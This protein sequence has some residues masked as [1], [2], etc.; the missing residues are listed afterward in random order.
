MCDRWGDLLSIKRLTVCLGTTYLTS[1]ISSTGLQGQTLTE[2]EPVVMKPGESHK[3]TCTAAGFTFS[4]YYMAWIRQAPGKGLE[5]IAYISSG[6]VSKFYSQSVQG[7]STISRDNDKDQVYL[8]MNSLKTEDSAVYYCAREPQWHRN[9]QSCTKTD[10]HWSH[11][12]N[13]GVTVQKRSPTRQLWEEKDLL[14][15]YHYVWVY[16]WYGSRIPCVLFN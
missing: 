15:Y 1:L 2:S 9:L 14:H 12:R 7:R 8:Q 11:M 16:H 13:W 5:C 3:L 10:K 6:S 4:S